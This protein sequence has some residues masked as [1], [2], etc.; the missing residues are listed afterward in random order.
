MSTEL[1]KARQRLAAVR[2]QLKQ[3]KSMPAVQAVHDSLILILKSSLMKSEKDEFAKLL[4]DAVGALN[5]DPGLRKIYPLVIQYTPGEEKALLD[6]IYELLQEMQNLV[7]E[8]AKKDLAE[9][10]RRKMETLAQGQAK[11][12]AQKYEE[13]KLLFDQLVA[14]FPHDTDLKADIADR[15]LKVGRYQDALGYLEEALRHDPNAIHL[16]N[17]IGIVLRKMQDFA[18]AE[19]YYL[20]AQEIADNDEYL[21]FNIGR[22]Y[23][24][25]KKWPEVEKAAQRALKVNPGFAEAEKMLAFARKMMGK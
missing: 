6:A 20:K 16:Y 9:L 22:L 14:E 13:A 23:I 11:L 15:F 8:D 7:T 17:R 19:K 3:G 12:D 24:D 25:W 5:A 18:T 2:T 1:I 4:G 10:E 21:F